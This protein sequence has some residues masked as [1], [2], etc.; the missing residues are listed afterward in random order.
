MQL[1]MRVGVATVGTLAAA[2][3]MQDLDSEDT[4]LGKLPYSSK[5]VKHFAIDRIGK[6]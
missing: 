3:V 6:L 2:K 4:L 1:G 5:D